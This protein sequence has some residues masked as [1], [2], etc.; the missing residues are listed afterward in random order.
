MVIMLEGSP[1][2]G[3]RGPKRPLHTV[4]AP[5]LLGSPGGIII[6]KFIKK[7]T[8]LSYVPSSFF[9]PIPAYSPEV[10]IL[11]HHRG[12]GGAHHRHHRAPSDDGESPGSASAASRDWCW[13]TSRVSPA[14]W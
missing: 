7:E 6:N 4:D 12:R 9:E 10:A 13:R 3:D 5:D 2:K 14:G 1:N 8:V 11:E